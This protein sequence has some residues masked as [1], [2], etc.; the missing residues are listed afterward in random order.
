M[1]ERKPLG[2]GDG[3]RGSATGSRAAGG[4]GGRSGS[5]GRGGRG[6]GRGRG[7]GEPSPVKRQRRQFTPA[8]QAS[9][10]ALQVVADAGNVPTCALAHGKANMFLDGNPIVYSG[11]IE[12]V[13]PGRCYSP[14]PSSGAFRTLVFQVTRHFMTWRAVS[15]IL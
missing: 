2:V 4:R 10:A 7:R 5:E 8:Q 14:R 9:I 13:G 3:R 12:K 1:D 6:G 11:A 15:D